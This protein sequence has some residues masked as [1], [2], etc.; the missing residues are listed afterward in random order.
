MHTRCAEEGTLHNAQT[1]VHVFQQTPVRI[2]K[3]CA[4]C[5]VPLV[6]FDWFHKPERLVQELDRGVR[7]MVVVLVKQLRAWHG[8]VLFHGGDGA[9]L[10][11]VQKKETLYY[12]SHTHDPQ[13]PKISWLKMSKCLFATHA[14]HVP[15]YVSNAAQIMFGMDGSH[16]PN[17]SRY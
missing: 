8:R 15:G 2:G 6:V 12:I 4:R 7:R 14:A 10:G 17:A 16:S 3:G 9:K 13:N 5:A 11:S 1:C